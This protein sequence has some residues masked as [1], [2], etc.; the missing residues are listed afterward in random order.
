MTCRYPFMH[1]PEE[2]DCET[3]LHSLQRTVD[4]F[5]ASAA[6][7]KELARRDGLLLLMVWMVTFIV[8]LSV[9]AVAAHAG[10]SRA[11]RAYQMEARV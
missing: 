6:F 8:S 3:S 7:R 4:R 11:E 5:E 1:S 9:L 2:C 10:L